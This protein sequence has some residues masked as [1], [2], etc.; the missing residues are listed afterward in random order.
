MF[1]VV[2]NFSAELDHRLVHLG[3]DL[4]LEKNF[5]AF[6]NFLNVRPQLA[7]LWIDN[8]ELLFDTERISVVFLHSRKL[9]YASLSETQLIALTH[10]RSNIALRPRPVFFLYR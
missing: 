10:A 6:E 7:R 4:F 1:D 2:T 9:T 3:L 5:A 8:R